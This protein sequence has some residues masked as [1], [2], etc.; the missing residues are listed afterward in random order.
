MTRSAT[1]HQ[2]SRSVAI[3]LRKLCNVG[4]DFSAEDWLDARKNYGIS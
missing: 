3:A 2:I 1:S 4:D